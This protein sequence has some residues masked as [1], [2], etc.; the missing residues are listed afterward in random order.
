ML[1]GAMSALRNPKAHSNSETL[2]AEESFRRLST[3]SM[4]MYTIDDA[5]KYSGI[6]E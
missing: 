6:T 3:A 2:S 4:L 1:T 5:V